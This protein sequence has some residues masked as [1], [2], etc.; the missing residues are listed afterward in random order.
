MLLFMFLLSIVVVGNVLVSVAP[1]YDSLV[2]LFVLYRKE[3][4][5]MQMTS[6]ILRRVR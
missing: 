6:M 3:L 1:H 4:E 5:L 2:S